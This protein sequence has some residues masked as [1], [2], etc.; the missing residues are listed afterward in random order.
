MIICGVKTTHDG[1]VALIDD[2][3]LIF[4]IEMEKLDN[5]ERYSKIEDLDIVFKLIEEHGYSPADVDQFVLDGWHKT[6]K[7]RQWAGQEA[8]IVLAPYRRGLISDDLFGSYPHTVFDLTYQSYTHYAG[9]VASGYCTSPF[10]VRGEDALVLAWDAWMFPM[11][12]RINAESGGAETLG[13]V[14]PLIGDVYHR[15]GRHFP[16]FDRKIE[17]PHVL[18]LAGKIM[19]YIALGRPRDDVIAELARLTD[20]LVDQHIGPDW[21]TNDRRLQVDAG[22]RILEGIERDLRLDGVSG[23]DA[24]ASLHQFLQDRLLAGLQ[25]L[26]A[27]EAAGGIRNLCLVGGCA[28]NIKWNSA[29]RDSGLFDEVWV[30]PFPNDSGSAIGTAS[31]AMMQQSHRRSLDWNVYSG[32]ALRPSDPLPGWVGKECSLRGLAEVLHASGEAVVFL[33]G[34]AELGPRALGNRSILAP[35]GSPQMKDVLNDIKEREGYRPVAPI[36]L[37]DR[38]SGIFDPGTPDP[39]MLFDH[40]VRDEWAERVPAIRHL[41]GTARLQ[42]VT[43]ESNPAIAELLAA[44]EALSGIP[45]LCNTSANLKNSGFFPDARS[46]M[47]WGRTRY[48]WSEGTLYTRQD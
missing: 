16:P 28:L 26:S 4:S 48:V 7:V 41:D 2:G 40:A 42:T 12:Y 36:C 27:L 22:V 34:K 8:E 43:S 39:Y 9:H 19:A 44:Y 38:A 45:L 35:A 15:V 31:V 23:A 18:G 14:L 10:A 30:P 33:N 47:E 13:A 3:K 1:A 37:E 32:P 6:H 11:L 29:I 5:N 21:Q 17:F 24:L 46:A 25:E 20:A